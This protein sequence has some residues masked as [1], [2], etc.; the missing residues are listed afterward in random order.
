MKVVVIA[1]DGLPAWALGAYG[2][3]WIPTPN[4][5]EFAAQSVVFDQHIADVPRRLSREALVL[6]AGAALIDAPSLLPPWHVVLNRM[7]TPISNRSWTQSPDCCRPMMTQRCT[8]CKPPSPWSFAS[9]TPGWASDLQTRT[10]MM[11]RSSS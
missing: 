8:A 9:S 3:D 10:C 2:N 7:M 5:D 4:L 6:P 11:I 1:V